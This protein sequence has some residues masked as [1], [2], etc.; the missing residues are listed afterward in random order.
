MLGRVRGQALETS[1]AV[2]VREMSL[3]GMSIETSSAFLA[4]ALHEFHLT[5]GDGSPVTLRGRVRYSDGPLG[6]D[7]HPMYVTGIQ[8]VDE[9]QPEEP[10]PSIGEF[11][12][13]V[14]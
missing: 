7:D 11:L 13:H 8:F 9:D 1:V 10:A 5:L 3:G 12:G 2:T 4:G 6:P 14:R